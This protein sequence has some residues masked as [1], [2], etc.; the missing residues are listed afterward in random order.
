MSNKDTKTTYAKSKDMARPFQITEHQPPMVLDKDLKIREACAQLQRTPF[1]A[2][3]IEQ[4]DTW[5]E[6][7]LRS[8]R[9]VHGIT[10]IDKEQ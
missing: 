5:K 7:I 2:E 4:F 8:V 9:S 6:D 3:D 1:G 10:F